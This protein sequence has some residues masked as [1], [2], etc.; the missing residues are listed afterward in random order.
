M[1]MLAPVSSCLALGDH[2]KSSVEIPQ[3]ALGR[4]G[5]T[6]VG[7]SADV[8]ASPMHLEH[9]LER[10]GKKDLILRLAGVIKHTLK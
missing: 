2:V 1:L 8:R 4:P 9:N 5:L 6:H 10:T 7:C 3:P